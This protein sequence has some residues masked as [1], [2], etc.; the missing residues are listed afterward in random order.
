MP[1]EL[2][3]VQIEALRRQL[4]QQARLLQPV[5]TRLADRVAHPPVA[6]ADWHGPASAAYAGLDHRMRLRVAAAEHAVHAAL[7]STRIA[8][9]QLGG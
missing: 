1:I 7:A 9:A 5:V 6:P 8:L 4:E 2:D 3:P